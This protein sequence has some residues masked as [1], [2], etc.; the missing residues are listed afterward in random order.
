MAYVTKVEPIKNI[1]RQLGKTFH[2]SAKSFMLDQVY[3][4]MPS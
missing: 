2:N 1:P 3:E 4:I